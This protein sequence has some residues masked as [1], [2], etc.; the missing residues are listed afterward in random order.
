MS[1]FL[2]VLLLAAAALHAGWTLIV[3]QASDRELIMWP[4]V[5][6]S[7]ACS[8][9]L[10]LVRPSV[11]RMWPF[12]VASAAVEVA[13]Y[14]LL[15]AAYRLGDF[16]VVYPIARGAAPALLA[17]WSVL[18]L[19]ERPSAIGVGGILV[20]VAGLVIVGSG[21]PRSRSRQPDHEPAR[22]GTTQAAAWTS[23][24]R[25]EPPQRPGREAAAG[26]RPAVR[27]ARG[28]LPAIAIAALISVYS[29]IDGAAV[30]RADP[31]AYTV[32]VFAFTGLMLAPL[33]AARWGW[34]AIAA[35]A[36]LHPARIVVIGVFQCLAY[37]IVLYVY[38]RGS[39]AYAGAIREV[40]IVLAAV[41]G[42]LYLG[43][44]FGPRRVAGAAAMVV[45]IVLIAVAG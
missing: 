21:V 31:T 20:V 34:R 35:A 8:L 12:L 4:A 45:G 18:L 25:A 19:G 30:R 33:A 10:L 39:I 1:L 38:S 42:W 2:L 26:E 37:M 43:E 11:A 16:S 40:S 5:A 29:V 24:S 27:P 15:M 6:V 13:Y 3:K 28:A 41:A 17:T 22:A 44:E 7:A 23:P 36:R 9:P 32:V 14:A